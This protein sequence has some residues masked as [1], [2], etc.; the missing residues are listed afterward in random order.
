MT[1][2]NREEPRSLRDYLGVLRAHR[3]LI[4]L[5]TLLAA[6]LALAFSLAKSPTYEAKASLSFKDESQDVSLAGGTSVGTSDPADIAAAGAQTVTRPAVIARARKSLGL[7]EPARSIQDSVS[8]N[9]D[10]VSNLVTVTA[11]RGSAVSAARVANA[12]ARATAQIATRETQQRYLAAART[13]QSSKLNGQ[14]T[15]AFERQLQQ[16]RISRLLSLSAIAQ[17]VQIQRLADVPGAPASPRPLRNT[18]FAALIGLIL[19]CM[20]AFARDAF[21]QR[22]RSA[23]EVVEH[24]DL[25]VLGSIRSEA[26]GMQMPSQN[27][28]TVVS[29][30][31]L[32]AF[33]ILRSALEFMHGEK[34]P[35]SVI[36]T[37]PMAEEGKSTVAA[38]LAC[39][40]SLAGKRTLLIGADLRRP[41]LAE[42]FGAAQA[43]GLAEYLAGRV[44]PSD[45]LQVIELARPAT[46][47]S[48]GHVGSGVAAPLAFVSSGG[49]VPQPGELLG[50]GRFHEFLA[51]VSTAYDFVVV[52]SSPLLPVVDT[53]EL[54][55]HVEAILLCLRLGQTT[56]DQA[57]RAIAA[58]EH[59]PWR[60]TGL[61]VTGIEPGAGSYY[62]YYAYRHAEP[63]ASH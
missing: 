37:S 19:G 22:L 39:A 13:L 43:P 6:S 56:R 23:D 47:W 44:G 17:P 11:S 38:C 24:V 34:P 54:L 42:R 61:V 57:A 25:P 45:I 41:V 2:V 50:S 8:G 33:R 53:L 10:P 49:N 35:R 7:H 30:E 21:D 29:D 12:V 63:A 52:D 36:V 62:G 28:H 3:L 48:N 55:P 58:L 18:F 1:D 59:T 15:G 9:V 31:E 16:E 26:L 5:V 20:A 60:P 40:S 14:S 46:L 27:G 4:A 32:E 51:G